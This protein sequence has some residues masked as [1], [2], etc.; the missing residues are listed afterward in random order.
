MFSQSSNL[1]F[2]LADQEHLTKEARQEYEAKLDEKLQELGLYEEGMTIHQKEELLAVIVVSC[3]TAEKEE[4]KRQ[5]LQELLEDPGDM[6]R[7]DIE[8]SFQESAWLANEGSLLHPTSI[9]CPETSLSSN[10]S[11][12]YSCSADFDAALEEKHFNDL[13][14]SN[15]VDE[16]LDGSPPEIFECLSASKNTSD[17]Q[18]PSTSRDMKTKMRPFR[19][20]IQRKDRMSMRSIGSFTSPANED[21]TCMRTGEFIDKKIMFKQEKIQLEE[22]MS[23]WTPCLSPEEKCLSS[24]RFELQEKK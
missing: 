3:E 6:S 13:L 23:F 10:I 11:S 20:S 16:F 12:V 21:Q 17:L 9:V 15:S 22:S 24:S 4:T 2:S 5:I 7:N 14:N 18:Q 19:Q 8:F 1:E